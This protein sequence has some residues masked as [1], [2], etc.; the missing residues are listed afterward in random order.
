MERNVIQKISWRRYAL[1]RAPSS[2]Y[3]YYRYVNIQICIAPKLTIEILFAGYLTI[4]IL[5]RQAMCNEFSKCYN[6]VNICLWTNG[7]IV[8]QSEAQSI[9][10]QRNSF[11]P[12]I[13][14]SSIRSKL[15]KFRSAAWSLLHGSGFWIDVKAVSVNKWHWIDGSS[16]AGLSLSA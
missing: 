9:C 15:G 2:N 13:T 7:S 10:Q 3:C 1:S 6:D 4:I 12:R 11:L 5:A 16:L 8:S 14:N